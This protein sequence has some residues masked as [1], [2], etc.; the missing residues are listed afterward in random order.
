MNTISNEIYTNILEYLN[1]LESFKLCNLSNH[2]LN[3]IQN[4]LYWKN[5]C[6]K[7]TNEKSKH[8]FNL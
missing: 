2:I 3:E 8:Y 7:Y 6:K 1:P 5:E 4:C